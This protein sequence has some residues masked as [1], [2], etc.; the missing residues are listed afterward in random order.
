MVIRLPVHSAGKATCHKLAFQRPYYFRVCKAPMSSIRTDVKLC[1]GRES[2][3]LVCILVGH[4]TTFGRAHGYLPSPSQALPLL[5][6]A[7]GAYPAGMQPSAAHHL[8]KTILPGRTVFG[9]I[10]ML[11]CQFQICRTS[12]ALP[13]S[14]KQF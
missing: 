14:S 12:T 6:H 7:F 4:S 10:K 5:T 9:E 1:P 3:R 8:L 2:G 11:F 13:Q